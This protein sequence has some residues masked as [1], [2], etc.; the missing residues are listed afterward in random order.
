MKHFEL[1]GTVRQAGNNAAVK[2]I[3]KQG[4]V[5]CNLYG[6]GMKENILFSITDKDLKRA[7]NTPSS[8]IIDLVLDNGEKFTAIIQELQ[9]HPVTDI[10]LHV[11][12]LSVSQ[13]KPITISVP[14]EVDG[15]PVGVQRGGKFVLLKRNLTISALMNDLPDTVGIDVT[16]LD[17]EKRILA[18]D[19]KFD[20]FS[21]VS[22]K[23]TIICTV[24]SSRQIAADIAHEE[25]IE[26]ADATA[27]AAP[28]AEPAAAD[29]TP[30][31]DSSADAASKK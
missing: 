20:N 1:N 21:I 31:A 7:I 23:A 14:V 24:K 2:A 30:A 18:G 5:P 15:H 27:P 4:L 25:A 8:F 6:P 3:R 19:L 13:D 9:F 12:F 11:D 22:D 29:A 16:N 10:C 26:A 17:L 28:A